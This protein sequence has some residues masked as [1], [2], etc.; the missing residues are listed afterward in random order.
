MMVRWTSILRAR[1]YDW[2]AR[3]RIFYKY[4]FSLLPLFFLLFTCPSVRIKKNFKKSP[5]YSRRRGTDDVFIRAFCPVDDLDTRAFICQFREDFDYN[6]RILW[7]Q[8]SSS[9]D[10]EDS[11]L[12]LILLD[13]D[14]FEKIWFKVKLQV[15]HNNLRYRMFV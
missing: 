4:V 7:L 3:S 8:I 2:L 13:N 1:P 6:V 12:R 5:Y 9:C 11:V 10:S 14:F 15:W